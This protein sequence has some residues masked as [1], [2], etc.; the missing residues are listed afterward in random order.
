MNQKKYDESE[1]L[2]NE[3]IL[4]AERSLG[5]AHPLVVQ[6]KGRLYTLRSVRGNK[7]DAVGPYRELLATCDRESGRNTPL[8]IEIATSFGEALGRLGLQTSRI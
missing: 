6:S 7:A 5:P 4:N 1:A 2:T 8:S 3:L